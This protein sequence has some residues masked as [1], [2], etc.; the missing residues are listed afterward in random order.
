MC[1]L[2]LNFAFSKVPV[3]LALKSA[4]TLA[5]ERSQRTAGAYCVCGQFITREGN[6]KPEGDV[7]SD[8]KSSQ[9][10]MSYRPEC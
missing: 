9:A 6:E 4:I 10:A 2:L 5:S 8:C 7:R 1:F 3:F